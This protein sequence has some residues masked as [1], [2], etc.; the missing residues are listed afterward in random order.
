M[1]SSALLPD[2]SGLLIA[3]GRSVSSVLSDVWLLSGIKNDASPSN[4]KL[5][6]KN[7]EDNEKLASSNQEDDPAT[8]ISVLSTPDE[9]NSTSSIEVS[10]VQP[11]V[12]EDI[13]EHMT[14]M[15]THP[16]FWSRV[17]ALELP[18][19]RCAHTAVVSDGDLI[20]FGGFTGQGIS[21]DL[22]IA[23]N[24]AEIFAS[25]S[26]TLSENETETTPSDMLS[27]PISAHW[28]CLEISR[29][30][31][32]RFAHCMSAVA[33]SIVKKEETDDNGIIIFGGINATQDFNDVWILSNATTKIS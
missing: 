13:S 24:L 18:H 21:E 4:L 22:I 33:L 1:H 6:D 29:P 9:S 20:L 30:I 31:D 26:S 28:M 27:K 16:L 19:P 32:G 15:A 3:G 25:P 10:Q 8:L 11:Q 17:D 12:K 7:N 5:P 23:K 14:E 2:S